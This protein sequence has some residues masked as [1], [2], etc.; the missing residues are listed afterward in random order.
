[1]SNPVRDYWIEAVSSSL[2][3]Q[4]VLATEAQIAAI[5][6]DME[7]AADSRGQAFG[8]PTDP[9]TSALTRQERELGASH[10]RREQALEQEKEVY[11][12][13]LAN[14]LGVTSRSLVCNNG[15]VEFWS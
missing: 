10:A 8:W 13:A 2:D 9:V 12:Q 11:K 5:G 6:K 15:R 3:E 7:D 4:E 14:K 1:M